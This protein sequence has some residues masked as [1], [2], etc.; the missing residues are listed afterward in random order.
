[1]KV[2]KIICWTNGKN[3]CLTVF[4]KTDEGYAGKIEIRNG[5]PKKAISY[6]L[7]HM[8]Y[9]DKWVP[10]TLVECTVEEMPA[11]KQALFDTALKYSEPKY[12]FGAETKELHDRLVKEYGDF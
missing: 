2:Q 4:F 8:A 3:D 11:D 10:Y 6:I 1:M 5:D 7:P 12:S 9:W